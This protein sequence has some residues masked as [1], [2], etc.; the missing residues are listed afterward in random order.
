MI[1]II[2]ISLAMV[3]LVV[4]L[5]LV[6]PYKNWK[7]NFDSRQYQ[8]ITILDSKNNRHNLAE[9]LQLVE[10]RP[11]PDIS[12]VVPAY[13]EE[14]RLPLMLADVATFIQ[15]RGTP[16]EIIVVND[17]SQDS[18]TQ[19][20]LEQAGKLRLNLVVVEYPKNRGKG[21][22]VRAGMSLV[23]GKYALMV[24]ADG[25]TTFAELEHVWGRL[26]ELK[27]KQENG[28]VMV[29]GSRRIVG[30][31]KVERKW[32]RKFIS[33]VFK[34]VITVL[35]GIRSQDTQ[36]G[37]KLFTR[38]ASR[39]LFRTL[40]IERFAFDV[41]LFFL[42]NRFGV[43]TGEVGV[44]W[45]DVD[46]SKLSIVDASVNMFRDVLMIRL[47]YLLGLWRYSDSVKVK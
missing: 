5:W 16:H 45:R 9:Y 3:L 8:P 41:E 12:L 19:V 33:F 14:E 21:G 7:K 28:L 27:T 10:S 2:A 15:P 29:V 26:E 22:A 37:F 1:H 38:E 31:G 24:D 47:Y 34:M 13:N 18:T 46:G 6:Q 20:A 44:E 42:C 40:H 32:Y 30:E 35:L 4:V 23:R 39:I 17:G 25:A 36:C 11:E 43:A